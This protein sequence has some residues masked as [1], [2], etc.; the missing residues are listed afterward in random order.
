MA[1]KELSQHLQ[2]IGLSEKESLV[3]LAAL[4][5][6][7][8]PVQTIAN[9]AKV[10]RATTYVVLESLMKKGIVTTFEQGKKTLYIAEGPHALYAIIREQEMELM[11]VEDD[12]ESMMP[13]LNSIY[14]LH[15]NKPIVRFYEGKEG[16]NKVLQERLDDK[17]EQV[18][19]FFPV[20]QT[21]EIFT[22]EEM[23]DYRKKR[24]S[25]STRFD[26]IYCAQAAQEESIEL[27]KLIPVD[28]AQYPFYCDICVYQDKVSLSSLKGH[29]SSVIIQNKEV[30]KTV[31][32][33][34]DLIAEH[35]SSQ[36]KKSI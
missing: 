33:I 31:E 12:L 19:V 9:K 1:T 28:Q 20:E 8:A 11:R 30:A 5:L 32:A 10:N 22:H 26:G 18:K 21:D 36:N 13:Q 25:R 16:L 17:P 14:N 34:F 29:I 27:G 35:L 7:Q 3:Y 23:A 6:G 4:E 24:I 2:E 15:P